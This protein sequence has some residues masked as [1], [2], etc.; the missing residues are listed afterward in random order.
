[1]THYK[2]SDASKAAGVRT[3]RMQK[4]IERG[5]IRLTSRDR[6]SRTAGEPHR[7]SRARVVQFAI[8]QRLIEVG[9]KPSIAATAAF[10]FSDGRATDQDACGTSRPRV[11]LIGLP[12]GAI[13][14]LSLP[15]D[16]SVEELLFNEHAAFVVNCS[17]IAR[18]VDVALSQTNKVNN[19]SI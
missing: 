9:V 18:Q 2:V 12:Y 4:A 19:E 13:K 8:T 5:N 14:L 17:A 16:G 11:V 3:A 1:M 7:L 6:P 15:P 10:E